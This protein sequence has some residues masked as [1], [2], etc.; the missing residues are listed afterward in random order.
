MD[1]C[2][3]CNKDISESAEVEGTTYHAAPPSFLR[4]PE[5]SVSEPDIDSVEENAVS[6]GG[7]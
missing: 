5:K 7:G 3:K 1:S 4:V 6:F 2:L